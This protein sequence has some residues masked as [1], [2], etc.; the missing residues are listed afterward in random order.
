M[1]RISI[2]IKC[3]WSSCVFWSIA[4][5]DPTFVASW[6]PTGSV[7]TGERG[8]DRLHHGVPHLHRRAGNVCLLLLDGQQNQ[9]TPAVSVRQPAHHGDN[10]AP[11][12]HALTVAVPRQEVQVVSTQLSQHGAHHHL[13]H[14]PVSRG[15]PQGC[16][17]KISGALGFCTRVWRCGIKYWP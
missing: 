12:T 16:R 4:A 15:R 7:A 1:C 8:D 10:P 9:G 6:S 17:C 13:R 14:V 3:E 11:V 2:T 5:I